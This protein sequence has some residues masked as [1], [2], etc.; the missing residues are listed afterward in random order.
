[1]GT[2][3]FT[4]ADL[5]ENRQGRVSQAQ[6]QMLREDGRSALGVAAGMTVAWLAANGFF[7]F[8]GD[9][10]RVM[11]LLFAAI[12]G[13]FFLGL[14]ALSLQRFVYCGLDAGSAPA[15]LEGKLV[16][17]ISYTRGGE[18][19]S[20]SVG[21]KQVICPSKRCNQLPSVEGTCRAYV[22]AR[23]RYLLAVEPRHG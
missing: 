7:A 17:D 13:I 15:V 16:V 10:D 1:M 4:E 5:A 6:K 12:V 20:V 19:A 8:V 9:G 3:G 11:T 21:G 22:A 2:T 18:R 23:S 14:A